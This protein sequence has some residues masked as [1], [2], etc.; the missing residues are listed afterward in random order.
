MRSSDYSLLLGPIALA[1]TFS[2]LHFYWCVYVA[3]D[4]LACRYRGSSSVAGQPPS[5]R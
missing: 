4:A 1:L 3:E 2:S 5:G